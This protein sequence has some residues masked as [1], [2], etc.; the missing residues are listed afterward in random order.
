MRPL[1]ASVPV[2]SWLE[3]R[4]STPRLG[5]LKHTASCGI[6]PVAFHIRSSR[7]FEREDSAGANDVNSRCE[8]GREVKMLP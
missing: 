5:R 6:I 3:I 1:H 2:L 7:Q 8:V 4:P